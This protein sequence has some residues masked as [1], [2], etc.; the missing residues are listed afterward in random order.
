MAEQAGTAQ[1]VLATRAG[2]V[3]SSIA[4]VIALAQLVGIVI[5]VGAFIS[6]H[7]Q[8][9]SELEL[10]GYS[11][12]HSPIIPEAQTMIGPWVLGVPVLTALVA[13]VAWGLWH[14][15]SWGRRS[16]IVLCLALIAVGVTIAYMVRADIGQSF[17]LADAEQEQLA[18]EG[19]SAV[20]RPI[21]T[22]CAFYGVILGILALPSVGRVF[23]QATAEHEAAERRFRVDRDPTRT[24]FKVGHEV[25]Q[26]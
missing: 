8:M 22:L 6:Y 11:A 26:L 13:I 10:Q 21:F 2:Q 12:E 24:H 1:A 4:R 3:V 15:R 17:L 25:E 18:A 23:A 19:V 16:G 7:A 20:L 9:S 14:L 5:L